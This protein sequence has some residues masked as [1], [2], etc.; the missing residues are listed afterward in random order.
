MNALLAMLSEDGGGQSVSTMRV[1]AVLIVAT[2]LGGWLTVS[3]Q[4]RELQDLSTNQT[5]LVLGALGIKAYQ[6]GKEADPAAK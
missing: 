2:V 6:R 5:V 4:K 1:C 3:L